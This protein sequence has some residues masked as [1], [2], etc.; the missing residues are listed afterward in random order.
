[1]ERENK[2]KKLRRSILTLHMLRNILRKIAWVMLVCSVLTYL[3]Y[4]VSKPYILAIMCSTATFGCFMFIGLSS[5]IDMISL[6][7]E[8]IFEK[9]VKISN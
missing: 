4:L 2:L 5:L 3:G 6:A 1:M 7:V 8:C 9:T